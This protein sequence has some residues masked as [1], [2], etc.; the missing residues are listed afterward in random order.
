MRQPCQDEF[1]DLLHCKDCG[2]HI[3]DN[4]PQKGLCEGCLIIKEARE[5]R[6]RDQ[7]YFDMLGKGMLR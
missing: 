7:V 3:A 1:C 2:E 5:N 6:E 4:T